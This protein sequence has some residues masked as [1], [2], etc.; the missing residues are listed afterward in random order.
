MGQLVCRLG[1]QLLGKI[2]LFLV[3]SG[4]KEVLA[5]LGGFEGLWKIE[6]SLLSLVKQALLVP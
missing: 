5:F 4:R 1:S 2:R 6:C 3:G